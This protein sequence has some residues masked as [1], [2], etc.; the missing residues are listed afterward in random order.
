MNAH[1]SD[2]SVAK[3]RTAIH[4]IEAQVTSVPPAAALSDAISELIGILD[5]GPEPDTR[6]CPRCHGV[7]MR[8]ASRCVHCWST[9]EAL[10]RLHKAVAQ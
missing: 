1:Y 3:L 6:A 5:L 8:E 7:I 10:P 4:R 9:F 2:E